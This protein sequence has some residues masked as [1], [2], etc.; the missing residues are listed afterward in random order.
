MKGET[1]LLSWWLH[2]LAI[3]LLEQSTNSD[4]EHWTVV[5][6]KNVVSL[7][8]CG[9]N[10]GLQKSRAMFSNETSELANGSSVCKGCCRSRAVSSDPA[11]HNPLSWADRKIC[12]T[13]P[14]SELSLHPLPCAIRHLVIWL[15]HQIINFYSFL[16]ASFFTHTW[17]KLLHHLFMWTH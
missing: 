12:N 13:I 8:A 3:L 9:R 5:L 1:P 7:G 15:S 10:R 17:K 4:K 2:G 14:F 6:C 16:S 11:P